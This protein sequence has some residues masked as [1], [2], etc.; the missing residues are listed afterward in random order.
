MARRWKSNKTSSGDDWTILIT[1][2]FCWA[3]SINTL[4]AAGLGGIN[5]ITVTPLEHAQIALRTLWISNFLL[6][7]ALYTVKIS[8]L[9]FYWHIFYINDRFR[10]ACIGMIGLLS[11][12]WMAN[13]VCV[14]LI[15]DPIDSSWK[16][17]ARA[18]HRFD[19]NSWYLWYCGLSIFFD[20]AILCFPL[21]VIR[22][23]KVNTRRKVS[24]IGI[25]WLGGF[26][27]ISA[28]VRFVLFY[29]SIHGLTDFGK[30]QY[31]SITNAFIWSEI[32]PNTS[33]IAAC[34]PT[35]G[36]F[37]RENGIMPKFIHSMRSTFG[38]SSTSEHKTSISMQGKAYSVGYLELENATSSK[39]STGDI[40]M[41]R[42]TTVS[43]APNSNIK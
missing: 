28:I 38:M 26:V 2:V 17:A 41:E 27:C 23:L 22:T 35:Y 10:K 39:K 13:I 4:I 29:Q 9:L 8:I 37:F 31:S 16:N 21:P 20:L 1:L 12:W 40:V 32:E 34:L 14:F 43:V 7:T 24:I 3:H 11:A 18:K 6:I 30:N 42:A 5:R 15:G 36:P 25:F 19:F 33:V